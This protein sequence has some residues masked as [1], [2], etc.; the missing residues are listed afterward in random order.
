SEFVPT[1][2]QGVG[3]KVR[4]TTA[5][6]V[7]C[8]APGPKPWDSLAWASADSMRNP[9]K[10]ASVEGYAL[11]AARSGIPHMQSLLASASKGCCHDAEIYCSGRCRRSLDWPCGRGG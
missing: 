6:A 5:R 1:Q 9:C 11:C 4:P 8:S 3:L 2:R 7:A 10:S